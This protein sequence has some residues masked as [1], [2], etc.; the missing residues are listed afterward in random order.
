MNAVNKTNDASYEFV[1]PNI[2]K[3]AGKKVPMVFPT[4]ECI[5]K[6]GEFLTLRRQ[7]T[8]VDFGTDLRPVNINADEANLNIGATLIMRHHNKNADAESC[9]I[10]F[11]D[12]EIG[13][14]VDPGTESVK[15]LVWNGTRLLLVGERP[16]IE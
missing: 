4:A 2:A 1:A 10:R 7:L 8:I 12:D 11:G 5:D 14:V 13:F 15:M 16:F 9:R 3:D 6:P